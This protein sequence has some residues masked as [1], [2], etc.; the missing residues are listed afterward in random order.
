MGVTLHPLL[1][2]L[3]IAIGAVICG[4]DTWVEM[5]AYGRAKAEWLK[6]CLELPLGIPSHDTFAPV[7]MR[8]KPAELQRCFLSWLR[9]VSKVTQGEVVAIE[10][11]TLRRSFD[12]AAGKGALH[13]V[14]VWATA[15]RVVV[16]QRKGEE[17]SN[18]LTAIP[19]VWQLLEVEGGIVPIDALGCQKDLARTIV[20]Q[21]ADYGLARKGQVPEPEEEVPHFSL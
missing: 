7:P 17:N 2:S 9:A 3:V 13:M 12:R 21:G 16:G 6:Q 4:A 10:G 1:D 8:L 18:E 20:E 19:A 5:E 15:N 14:S 11:K